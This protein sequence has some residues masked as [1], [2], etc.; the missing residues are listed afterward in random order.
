MFT[1]MTSLCFA[2]DDILGRIEH[3]H[4]GAQWENDTNYVDL[5]GQNLGKTAGC[6]KAPFQPN[7]HP[8]WSVCH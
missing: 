3:P 6:L 7:I 1:F 5:H 2:P 4:M 8:I